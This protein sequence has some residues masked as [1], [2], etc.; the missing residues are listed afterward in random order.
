MGLSGLLRKA[1]EVTVDFELEL[2]L[3]TMSGTCRPGLAN[4]LMCVRALTECPHTF[5]NSEWS[6]GVLSLTQPTSC[7]SLPQ[8]FKSCLS[9]TQKVKTTV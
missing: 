7:C 4:K 8:F 3:G 9:N 6:S 5:D 1:V 2:A